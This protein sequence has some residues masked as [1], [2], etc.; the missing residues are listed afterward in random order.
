MGLQKAQKSGAQKLPSLEPQR[1]LPQGRDKG[2]IFISCLF[3]GA[4]NGDSRG[5]KELTQSRPGWEELPVSWLG[6]NISWKSL[7]SPVIKE[8]GEFWDGYMGPADV[9]TVPSV[10]RS[11][12]GL[13]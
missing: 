12:H 9:M 8:A 3:K 7:W 11:P 2:F 5:P 1:P 10:F 6:N 13:P 4:G